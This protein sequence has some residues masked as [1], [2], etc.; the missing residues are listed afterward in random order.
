M[1]SE[2]V[3]PVMSCRSDDVIGGGQASR[4]SSRSLMAMMQLRLMATFAHALSCAHAH[5]HTHTQNTQTTTMN[6]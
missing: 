5:T 2:F 4:P 1:F 6:T 3:S